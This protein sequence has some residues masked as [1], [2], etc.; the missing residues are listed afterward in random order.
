MMKEAGISFPVSRPEMLA[1]AEYE[2]D[3]S[4]FFASMIL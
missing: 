4:P 1:P 2:S 3:A